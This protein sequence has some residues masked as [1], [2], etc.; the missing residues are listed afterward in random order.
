[1]QGHR[2]VRQPRPRPAKTVYSSGEAFRENRIPTRHTK[3]APVIASYEEP[4]IEMTE[5]P[6][7]YI[8]SYEEPE[9][10][11]TSYEEPETEAPESVVISYEEPDIIVAYNEPGTVEPEIIYGVP[12]NSWTEVVDG[13]PTPASTPSLGH[14]TRHDPN[15]SSKEHTEP[16]ISVVEMPTYREADAF[17]PVAPPPSYHAP[18]TPRPTASYHAPTS[19]PTPPPYSRSAA[20]AAVVGSEAGPRFPLG[21]VHPAP[22]LER[23]S[24]ASADTEQRDSVGA[25]SSFS[26]FR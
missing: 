11:D 10:L 1:M 13:G 20:Q 15:P 18:A 12:D 6:E 9:I 22:L 21:P 19:P 8:T 4:Q 3:P 17:Q 24:R 25:I 26:F 16:V 2:P 14:T 7:V 5:E 23:I